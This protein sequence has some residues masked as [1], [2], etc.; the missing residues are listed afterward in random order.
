MQSEWGILNPKLGELED[1]P[2]SLLLGRSISEHINLLCVLAWSH[3]Q[4]MD[5]CAEGPCIET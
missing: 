2:A 3:W 1:L 4:A 5:Q